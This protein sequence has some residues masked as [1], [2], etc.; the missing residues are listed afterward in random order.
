LT[1]GYQ[2]WFNPNIKKY[3][4]DLAKARELLKEIGIEDRNGDGILTDA[5]GNK[6]EFVLNT[7]TGNGARE[8]TA[9][10]RVR[11]AEARFQ[12]HLSAD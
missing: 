3:P 6:I 12:C 11:F 5:D 7:N 4:H 9:V 2:K 10:H 8:K 1:P